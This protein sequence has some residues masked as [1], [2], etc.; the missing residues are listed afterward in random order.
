MVTHTFVFLGRAANPLCSVKSIRE[1][2]SDVLK[3]TQR[4]QDLQWG[5]GDIFNRQ[6]DCQYKFCVSQND[7]IVKQED[8]LCLYI[9]EQANM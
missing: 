3:L 6:K 2:E 4:I 9:G 1:A 7:R 5:H 8:D